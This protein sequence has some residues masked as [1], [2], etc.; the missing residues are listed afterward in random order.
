[1]QEVITGDWLVKVDDH[2]KVIRVDTTEALASRLGDENVQRAV[3]AR[4]DA[5]RTARVA[6]PDVATWGDEY[7]R[8]AY[9]AIARDD[10]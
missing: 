4:L 10:D 9:Q 5:D 6:P 8:A 7:L 1:M 2:G 3:L